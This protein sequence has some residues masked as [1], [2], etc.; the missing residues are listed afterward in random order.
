MIFGILLLFCFTS[1]PHNHGDASRG[2]NG[3]IALKVQSTTAGRGAAQAVP[4][5][6]SPAVKTKVKRQFRTPP[7]MNIPPVFLMFAVPIVMLLMLYIL[8]MILNDME[9]DEQESVEEL[10]GTLN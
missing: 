3:G 5:N 9:G 2:Q 8:G 6:A 10:F 1:V 7:E 4:D